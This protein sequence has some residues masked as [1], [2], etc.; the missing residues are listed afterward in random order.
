MYKLI[1][2]FSLVTTFTISKAGG[3]T[4]I[5]WITNNS[6][7]WFDADNWEEGVVPFD[8]VDVR[9]GVTDID[10][11]RD[12]VDINNF[13]NGVSLPNSLLR[14]ERKITFN[15][16]SP[17]GDPLL[18]DDGM[19]FDLMNINGDGGAAVIFNVPVVADTMTSNRHGGVFNREITVNNILSESQHQDD[20]Q[21]NAAATGPINYI[22][23]DENRG[24]DGDSIDGSFAIN[25]DLQI[26]QVEH[27]W[28]HMMI[29][30]NA[31]VEV[32][33]Y[34]YFEYVN[35]AE[36]NRINPI[37]IDGSLNVNVFVIYDTALNTFSDLEPGSYGSTGNETTDFQTDFIFG[38]GV[39]VVNLSDAVF[40]DGFEPDV[41]LQD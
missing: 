33:H 32:K 34:L 37:S 8:G 2:I 6:G 12:E 24:A 11:S 31:T 25:S 41:N 5:N 21:I 29:G 16:G 3:L 7:S 30:L 17:L 28:G 14:L 20:W 15:D 23:I 35:E 27:D 26:N 1:L 22:L 19:V 10:L 13:S 9:F 40:S 36:N 38:E 39:L 4:N 18:A